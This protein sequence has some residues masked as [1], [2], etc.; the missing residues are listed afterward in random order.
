M[1]TALGREDIVR[2]R[3]GGVTVDWDVEALCVGCF[4]GDRDSVAVLPEV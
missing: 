1:L 3:L 4:M 2:L